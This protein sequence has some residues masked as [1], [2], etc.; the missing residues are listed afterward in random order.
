[1]KNLIIAIDG[2]AASGKSTT[3]KI[4]AKKLGI[5]PIDTGAMYRAV[6]LKALRL[7]IPIE[8]RE[9][10]E[11]LARHTEIT[12]KLVEG[13]VRTFLDEVDVTE[14]IRS[15]EVDKAVSLVS[16]YAGVRKRLVEL[17]RKMAEQG[18]VVLEGRDIG[19]VVLPDAPLKI[20]MDA[21]LEE[22]ARRRLGDLKKKGANPTLEEVMEELR[23]RDEFDSK[24]EIAPLK[25][26]D[27]AIYIDTTRLTVEEQV[28]II[29]KEVEKRF[30]GDD[31]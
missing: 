13:T 5:L 30:G 19:T 10:I 24:R 9:A 6:T 17:Q 14:D 25:R 15:P 18:N 31:P 28:S 27:D 11:E 23:R 1:M 20:Y 26:A 16:S 3:A 2:T 8:N 29:L 7:G 12:Q 22:R 21:S 4:L